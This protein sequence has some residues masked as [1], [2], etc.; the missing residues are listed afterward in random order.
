MAAHFWR[1]ESRW[2]VVITLTELQK[3]SPVSSVEK[4]KKQP[5]YVAE[6]QRDRG[7]D[8]VWQKKE[9]NRK[10]EEYS[11]RRKL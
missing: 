3:L 11:G 8:G 7:L 1:L 4:A 6:S 2:K 10:A 5:I 9:T